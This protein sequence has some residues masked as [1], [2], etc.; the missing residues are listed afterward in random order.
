MC[1]A[2]TIPVDIISYRSYRLQAKLN[3]KMTNVESSPAKSRKDVAG[4]RD[5]ASGLTR[6]YHSPDFSV[7]FS[8][9]E[10]GVAAHRPTSSL[11]HF[12]GCSYSHHCCWSSPDDVDRIRAFP[13][14]HSWNRRCS[15]RCRG[16]LVKISVNSSR[17]G[18]HFCSLCWCPRVLSPFTWRSILIIFS[19]KFNAKMYSYL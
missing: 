17:S 11:N 18:S 7:Y 1:G 2:S 12:Y 6:N 16:E 5:V 15:S 19:R 13:S 8:C 4:G 10:D 14:C 3:I 9:Q